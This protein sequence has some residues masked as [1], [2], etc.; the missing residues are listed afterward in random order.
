MSKRKNIKQVEGTKTRSHYNSDD[1]NNLFIEKWVD[2]EYGLESDEEIIQCKPPYP[3]YLFVTSNGR[4]FSVWGKK[5][6][7]K[8]VDTLTDTGTNR[9][10]IMWRYTIRGHHVTVDKIVDDHFNTDE[11]EDYDGP[12]E[13][14]HISGMKHWE[15][16][17]VFKASKRSNI[18][19][20][21]REHI[22]EFATKISEGTAQKWLDKNYTRLSDTELEFVEKNL[23][24]QKFSDD[25]IVWKEIVNEYGKHGVKAVR[26]KDMRQIEPIE[27]SGEDAFIEGKDFI[28]T[29]GYIFLSEGNGKFLQKN[30]NILNNA[31]DYLFSDDV[32]STV[33]NCFEYEDIIVFYKK[34]KEVSAGPI[35]A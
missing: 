6:K 33:Y 4:L 19:K 30:K 15:P 18:Q 7:Q 35:K 26:M 11:W 32:S 17:D 22:H 2:Y 28:I 5:I 31:V 29:D 20:I 9:D 27:C 12:K 1:W 21:P 13:L 23:P 34:L 14:H 16:E 24:Y 25:V 3:P 8:A 10:Q